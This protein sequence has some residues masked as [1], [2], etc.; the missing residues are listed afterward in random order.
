[1]VR[2]I[3]L[4]GSIV[5]AALSGCGGGAASRWSGEVGPMPEGGTFEGVWFSPQYGEMHLRQTGAQVI[6]EFTKD[7]RHGNIQGTTQGN[8][9]RFEWTERQ[10]LVPGRPAVTHGR[11]YWRFVVG[12]DGRNNLMGEWGLEQNELGGGSWNAYQLRGRRPRLS[13]DTGTPQDVQTAPSDPGQ[14]SSTPSSDVGGG[15]DDI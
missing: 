5:V 11:G 13:T 9:L 14:G 4:L 12:D 6:G 3:A 1:M 2:K 7:E 10:E 8:V 15:E